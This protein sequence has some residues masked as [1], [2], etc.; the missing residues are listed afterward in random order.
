MGNI[1]CCH[2]EK[3]TLDKKADNNIVELMQNIPPMVKPEIEITR[4]NE[5]ENEKKPKTFYGK[6]EEPLTVYKK[7]IKS[8]NNV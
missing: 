8:Y 7:G 4:L 5:N 1:F 3:K 2:N 6:I